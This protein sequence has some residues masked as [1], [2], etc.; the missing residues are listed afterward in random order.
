MQ[1]AL[2]ERAAAIQHRAE[3][4]LDRATA[5]GEPWLAGFAEPVLG[6]EETTRR[7]AIVIAAYRDKYGLDG[8][9]SP[10]GAGEGLTTTRKA[11]YA[12]AHAALNQLT[13]NVELTD[14]TRIYVD[15]YNRTVAAEPTAA[16]PHHE[17]S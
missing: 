3:I 15:I 11:D 5:A 6:Q 9:P 2:D 4:V 10:L 8:E 1:D 13:A 16:S 17:L 7:A 14:S 12:L